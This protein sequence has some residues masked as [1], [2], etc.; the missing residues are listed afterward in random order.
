MRQNTDVGIIDLVVDQLQLLLNVLRE[1]P[2][3][4][5]LHKIF[6]DVIC[7]GSIASRE[8]T[9][10]RRNST[11]ELSCRLPHNLRV[12]GRLRVA[13]IVLGSFICP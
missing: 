5:A 1:F 7:S 13:R 10:A 12:M 2:N 8:D 11:T 6:A 4:V 3:N 9:T